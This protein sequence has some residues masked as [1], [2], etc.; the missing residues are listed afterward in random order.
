M[1]HWRWILLLLLVP[2]LG[3]AAAAPAAEKVRA[4]VDSY[5]NS[6]QATILREFAEFLSI[7]NLAGDSANIRRNAEY[8]RRMLERRG[9]TARL[10]ESPGSPPA[11]YGELLTPGARYTLVFY[12]HYDGQ[13]VEEREWTGQPW[14][15]VLR[16]GVL[17]EGARDIPWDGLPASLPDEWRLYARSTSDDKG[18]IMGMLASLDALQAAGIPPSVNLKFFFEGEEEAGSP[19]LRS[20]LGQHAALLRADAWLLCD[21]PVHATRRPQLFFGVRGVTDLELTVYGPTRALHSGHYGNW[22]PNPVVE[23]THLLANLRDTDG[24]ILIPGFYDDVRPLSES[25]RRALERVPEVETQLMHDLGLARTE[26]GG[27]SLAALI[28]KPALNVR[29]VQAGRVAEQARNAIPTEARASIDFRLVPDQTPEKIRARVE[30]HLQSQGYF[31]VHAEPDME[32][33]RR[34]PRIVRLDWGAGYPA[35]RT[36]MDLPFARALV[37]V[38]GEALGQPVIE[39]PTVGGSVPQHVFQEVLRVPVISL[40]IANHDNNQHA[41]NENL[42]LRNLWDGMNAYAGVMARLDAVWQE[43]PGP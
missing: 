37:R 28:L 23:L 33:R 42:R 20:M 12:A 13:P 39:M 19:H 41:A 10:L 11:V 26:G 15:P 21:G 6:H 14:V 17:E 43:P 9:V 22:A 4:A 36:A 5:R 40:P 16:D 3:R 27:E 2:N 18:G 24:R 34:H 25:E 29:G 30:A 31:V 1:R 32:K 7:P 38:L 35:N 8:L